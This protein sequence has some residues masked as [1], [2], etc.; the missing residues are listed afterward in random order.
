MNTTTG[1]GHP[2]PQVRLLEESGLFTVDI[3]TSPPAAHPPRI[4]FIRESVRPHALSQVG[5]A[6]M[7]WRLSYQGILGLSWIA[8]IF[9]LM[10]SLVRN[11]TPDASSSCLACSSPPSGRS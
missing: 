4:G 10:N 11:R 8:R 7:N 9:S 5:C 1:S 2:H 3:S 6:I